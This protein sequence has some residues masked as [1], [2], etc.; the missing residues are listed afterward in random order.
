MTSDGADL[1]LGRAEFGKPRGCCFPQTVGGTVF[2][3]GLI[4]PTPKGVA[5][6]R[7]RERPAK[8]C[9]QEREVAARRSIDYAP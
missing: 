1:E 2:Q 8:F 5:E 3:S 7:S 4:A 9:H 6:P